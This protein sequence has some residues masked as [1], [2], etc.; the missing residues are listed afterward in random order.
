MPVMRALYVVIAIALAGCGS[1]SAGPSPP[2]T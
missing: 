2:D 1:D